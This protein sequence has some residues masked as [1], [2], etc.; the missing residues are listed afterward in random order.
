MVELKVLNKPPE[1]VINVL[2]AFFSVF[3]KNPNWESIRKELKNPQKVIKEAH[4]VD[5]NNLP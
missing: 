5:L 4:N 2:S 3:N 1:V